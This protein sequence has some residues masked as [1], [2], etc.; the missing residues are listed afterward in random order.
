MSDTSFPIQRLAKP[1]A[2]FGRGG[3]AV[4]KP[5]FRQAASTPSFLN[6][7]SA[8]SPEPKPQPVSAAP[9]FLM[10]EPTDRLEIGRVLTRTFVTLGR[11]ALPFAALLG[12]ALAPERI[13]V[14]L[15]T[16]QKVAEAISLIATGLTGL[17]LQGAATKAALTGFGGTKPELGDCIVK[18]LTA[19]FPLLGIGILAAL[20]VVAGTIALIV[21]GIMLAL[22]WSVYVPVYIAEA[23]GLRASL[24]RSAALTKGHRWK[25]LGLFMMLGLAMILLTVA[26]NMTA[27]FALAGATR[28]LITL[29]GA[30]MA[31]ALYAEL[32]LVKD[33]GSPQQLAQVFD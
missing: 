2:A 17:A 13:G 7:G 22:A 3:V 6:P 19:Y 11:N 24:G 31:A 12:L 18:G 28:L 16:D 1:R 4:A 27:G 32:C 9:A 8:A 25:I 10:D 26:E 21:P 15:V 20:G 29:L 14:N 5:V 33:G 23:P 30:V